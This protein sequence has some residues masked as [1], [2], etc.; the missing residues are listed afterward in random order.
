VKTTPPLP[1][2]SISPPDSSAATP[3]EPFAVRIIRNPV[4]AF[5]VSHAI[6]VLAQLEDSRE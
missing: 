2:Q 5:K 6:Q 4:L 1:V 3:S